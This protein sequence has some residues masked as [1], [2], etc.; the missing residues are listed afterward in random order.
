MDA[1][2]PRTSY[3]ASLIILLALHSTVCQ[4]LLL[5]DTPDPKISQF[6]LLKP[7][8]RQFHRREL[9]PLKQGTDVFTG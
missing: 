3:S 1:T 6:S 7:V 9:T 8:K 4:L 5:F 2:T